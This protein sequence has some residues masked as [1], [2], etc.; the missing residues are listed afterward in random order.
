MKPENKVK[1]V[2]ENS[3]KIPTNKG[4]STLIIGIVAVILLAGIAYAVLSGDSTSKKT[5]NE[6]KLPSYAYTNPL[7]LKAYKYATEHPEILEQ[8]PC[9]CGCGEHSGHRFLRDCFVHDDWTYDDHASFC[10]VCIGEAIKVQDYLAQG[11]TLKEARV[12]IDEEYSKKGGEGTNTPP[13]RNDYKPILSPKPAEK[14]TETAAQ[15][16][17]IDLSMLSLP[18]NFKSLSDGL[19]LIPPGIR[20]AYFANLKQGTGIESRAV[21]GTNF[22]GMPIIGMLNSEYYDS[23]WVELHDVGK[24][25]INVKSNPGEKTDNI[26]D[27]RP[28]IFDT[29]DKT[30]SVLALFKDQ[31]NAN[32]YNS[33]KSLLEKVDD[34]SAGFAKI[35]TN[36]PSFADLSYFGLI[37]SG[38]DVKG[39]LAFRIKDN[40]TIP[41]QKYNE[42]KDSSTNRG[43]KSYEVNTDN[44]TLIIRMTSSLDNVISEATQNY[45]I[46]I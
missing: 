11:K 15:P 37:R 38:S 23:S 22:Y 21:P 2:K 31:A 17:S 32:A 30:N 33:F 41:L 8:I 40:G 46:E 26:V 36:A 3:K 14:T 25:A 28:F 24:T 34:E 20:W 13:V 7:T 45:G 29:R 6:I 39:E 18:D 10:D 27:N 35:N 16:P 43:F 9:Y 12:L 5:G 1:N 44:N 4:N 42:L 19:K